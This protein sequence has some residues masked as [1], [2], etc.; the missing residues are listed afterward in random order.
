[1]DLEVD[2][3]WTNEEAELI[4]FWKFKVMVA[5]AMLHGRWRRYTEL[6]YIVSCTSI[7]LTRWN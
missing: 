1:M 4:K 2:G 3:L 6:P 5:P 7:N